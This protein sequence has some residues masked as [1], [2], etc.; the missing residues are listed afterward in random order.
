MVD[1]LTE[2]QIKA[3]LDNYIDDSFNAYQETGAD[4][5]KATDYYLGKPYGNEV[6]G[7]SSVTRR[8]VA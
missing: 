8:E 7:K 1:K 3:L 4:V 2:E 6:S 5:D